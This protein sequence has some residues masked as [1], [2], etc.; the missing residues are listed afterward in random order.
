MNFSDVRFLPFLLVI[1]T[2]L[3]AGCSTAPQ[4]ANITPVQTQNQEMAGGYSDSP[5]PSPSSEMTMASGQVPTPK[6]RQSLNVLRGKPFTINGTVRDRSIPEVQVWLLNG[7]IRTWSVP[8]MTDGSFQVSLSAD[9]TAGLPRG[10]SPALVIHYPTPP[11]QFTVNYDAVSANVTG[12]NAT[13]ERIL[14]GVNN[15]EYYPTTLVDYLD[16]AITEYGDGNS[17]DIYFPNGVDAWIKINV[18][19]PGPPGSM[20]VSGTTS[21]PIGALLSISVATANFHPSPKNYDWSHE[22]AEGKATII[23]GTNG[24]NTFST[25]ID[26]APL[27]TGK[28]LILVESRDAALQATA[29]SKAEI[30]APLP[31]QPEKGNYIDRPHLETPALAVNATM[32]PV[33]LEGELKIVPPGTRTK[34]NEMPYGS[35]IDCATDGI[36]RIFNESGIQFLAVYNSYEVHMMEVPNG[37][38]IDSE[39]VGNVSII[40]LN[41]NVILIKINEYQNMN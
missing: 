27:N 24:V 14:S 41:G 30:I 29:D 31:S 33:M 8:V 28:Y 3:F 32:Q 25:M 23:P 1:L 18:I 15:K 16:Q 12:T 40:R 37:A 9:E 39:S 11:D 5:A 6:V 22:I 13:P 20:N 17:C 7:T 21:L 10:F 34:N 35:I 19:S 36:C 4:P 2:V 38:M 26:T